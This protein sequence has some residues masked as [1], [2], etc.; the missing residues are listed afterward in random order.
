MAMSVL[1]VLILIYLF[2]KEYTVVR[3]LI[4]TV[5]LAVILASPYWYSIWKASQS[6]WYQSSVLRLG[7]FYTH[8]PLMNKLM[9]A[10]FAVYIMLVLFA[11]LR[12][13]KNGETGSY[14]QNWHWMLLAFI[15]GSLLAYNQQ[16]ITG[17]TI[18]P[19]HFA[20]YTI[21]LAMIVSVVLFYNIIKPWSRHIWGIGIFIIAAASFSFGIYTQ[22]GT[23]NRFYEY[24]ANRQSYAP[25]FNWFNEQKKD[26]VVLIADAPNDAPALD[27]LILAFTHC[28]IYNSGTVYS[29]MP[30]ERVY[31]N[32]FSTLFFNGITAE[33]IEEYIQENK[34]EIRGHLASNWKSLYG[35]P[36]FPDFQDTKLAGRIENFP[37]D[38]REFLSKNI[39]DELNK[40]RLDYVLSTGPLTEE[41]MLALPNLKKELE[42][43]GIIVYS[44]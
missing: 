38:Y 18:W 42:E 7:L 22:A 32:Y 17:K 27:M 30:D 35:A 3:N 21:P 29:L 33:N 9:S 28:N 34:N 5:F 11:F 43:N 12:H 25:L 10:V 44:F 19:Y 41:V 26:C 2:K 24:Y 1:A 13:R 36:D 8:Y 4:T 20:Q 6:E 23:Y 39:T 37:D 16:V 31:H 14:F 40:Y 15:L